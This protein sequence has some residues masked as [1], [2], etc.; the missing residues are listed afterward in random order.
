MAEILFEK[1]SSV[2][3]ETRKI[4]VEKQR[5]KVVKVDRKNFHRKKFLRKRDRQ[6]RRKGGLGAAPPVIRSDGAV[7]PPRRNRPYREKAPQGHFSALTA[8]VA[9]CL[10]GTLGGH[11]QRRS[12][13]ALE[14]GRRT[15]GERLTRERTERGQRRREK[16]EG[17]IQRRD[18]SKIL[19]YLRGGGYAPTT[20]YSCGF[21]LT[22]G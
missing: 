14:R 16:G 4:F 19:S 11:R 21:A 15:S 1:K 3:K 7:A 8:R 6:Y 13:P 17:K 12:I 9:A 22:K 10:C 20:G 5:K 18:R 2:R